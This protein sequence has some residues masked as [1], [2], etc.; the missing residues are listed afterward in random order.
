MITVITE[1]PFQSFYRLEI[2]E[3]VWLSWNE[4]WNR[5]SCITEY[6][7]DTCLKF[8]R[9]IFAV[10]GK[11]S[12]ESFGSFTVSSC[13]PESAVFREMSF[14][15]WFILLG[16]PIITS[17]LWWTVLSFF[18]SLE[19]FPH[20]IKG[21]IRWCWWWF[22]WPSAG[23]VDHSCL[24]IHDPILFMPFRSYPWQKEKEWIKT[25]AEG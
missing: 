14:C 17:G 9:E 5:F 8:C 22:C 20:F 21:K 10:L 13:K 24:M 19:W 25:E 2:W 16:L 23:D 18:L 12:I 6:A 1:T 15:W 4:M 7:N 3:E 11:C